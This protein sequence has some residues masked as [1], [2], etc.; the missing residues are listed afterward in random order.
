MPILSFGVKRVS[1]AEKSPSA[2]SS[3]FVTVFPTIVI[4]WGRGIAQNGYLIVEELGDITAF[5]KWKV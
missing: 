4:A 1:T 5:N 2:I 3:A